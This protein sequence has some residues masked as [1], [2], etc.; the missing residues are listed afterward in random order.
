[1]ESI[2]AFIIGYLFIPTTA[3]FTV[4]FL[5]MLI[6]EEFDLG[7]NDRIVDA[8]ERINKTKGANK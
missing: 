6:S 7:L 4:L 2:F 8:I 5:T 3:L 1:M